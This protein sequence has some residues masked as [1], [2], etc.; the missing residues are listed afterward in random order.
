MSE[1]YEYKTYESTVVEL[2]AGEYTA[3]ELRGILAEMED[4]NNKNQKMMEEVE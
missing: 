2:E 1:N 3:E 4:Y